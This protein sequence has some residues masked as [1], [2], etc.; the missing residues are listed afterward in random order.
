MVDPGPLTD[1][2]L[3]TAAKDI[4]VG[5]FEEVGN[6]FSG[7]DLAE[8]ELAE[9]VHPDDIRRIG[10]LIDSALVEVEVDWIG[11][12]LAEEVPE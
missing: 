4:I 2:E 7:Q 9:S 10:H 3:R 12:R 11:G 8:A 6:R 5:L 1:A